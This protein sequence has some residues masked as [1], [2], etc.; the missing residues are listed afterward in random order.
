MGNRVVFREFGYEVGLFFGLISLYLG[1]L[2]FLAVFSLPIMAADREPKVSCEPHL[3]GTFAERARALFSPEAADALVQRLRPDVERRLQGRATLEPS[4]LR[5]IFVVYLTARLE[6]LPES[7]RESVWETLRRR[8][9]VRVGSPFSRA[10]FSGH[11]M[12]WFGKPSIAISLPTDYRHTLVEFVV[13]AHE[14]EHVIQYAT[15]GPGSR[16]D[17]NPNHFTVYRFKLEQ[18]A[19]L[20]ESAFLLLFPKAVLENELSAIEKSTSLT[21]WEKEMGM[22]FLKAALSSKFSGDYLDRSAK[23]DRATMAQ[24][25][26][27][28]VQAYM[29]YAGAIALPSAFGLLCYFMGW[30]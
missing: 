14:V 13:L 16:S 11:A 10:S 1:S 12:S 6:K 20:A 27:W 30:L 22:W 8:R 29:S 23:D 4:L 2:I 26:R 17:L 24:M 25:Q 15:I 9:S 5:E 28:R 18:G 19:I 3:S 21:A 7:T